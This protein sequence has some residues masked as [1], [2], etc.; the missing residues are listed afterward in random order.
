MKK[1]IV[2][3]W[4]IMW[5]TIVGYA[6]S[7]HEAHQWRRQGDQQYQRNRLDQAEEAY[8]NA[9]A[10]DPTFQAAFNL[11]N[12][13]TKKG[14][15]EDAIRQYERSLELMEDPI[16][17]SRAWYNLGN[18]HF[19]NGQFDKSVNAYKQALIRNPDDLQAKQNLMMALEHL[20]Q[21]T[22]PPPQNEEQEGERDQ[23]E[24]EDQ[25]QSN[26]QPNREDQQGQSSS[27]ETQNTEQETEAQRLSNEQ[28]RKM[29]EIVNEEDQHVQEK[30]RR[31]EDMS[32]RRARDW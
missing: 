28:A 14:Q 15:Y 30:M 22:Q 9:N 32:P 26:N 29:L 10:I 6:Q 24:R 27:D 4:S 8:R 3:F 5:L 11:G 1:V 7:S 17:Q 25:S 16:D 2:I 19:L 18:A 21:E 31:K 13:I 23:D 20:R 12:T